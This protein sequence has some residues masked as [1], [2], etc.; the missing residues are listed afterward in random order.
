MAL[1]AEVAVVAHWKVELVGV[2]DVALLM[3]WANNRAGPVQFRF[4]NGV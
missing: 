2:V 4:S 1:R 3:W